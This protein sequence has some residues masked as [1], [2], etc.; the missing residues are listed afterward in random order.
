MLLSELYK[1]RYLLLVE[2]SL[3]ILYA[4]YD[5][6]PVLI[7]ISVILLSIILFSVFDRPILVIHF[8]IFS[9][10]I[11]AIV[12]VTSNTRGPTLLIE[13][14]F[15]LIFVGLGT[16]KILLSLQK[17]IDI[18]TIILLWIPFLIW[19]LLSGLAE[20]VEKLRILVFWKNY[21]A[22]F[23]AL[24]YTY[25]AIKNKLNLKSVV[26]GIIVW[27]LF[28]SLIEI[29]ILIELGG[30]TTGI[31]GLFF[32]KNLLSVGWGKSNYLAAF[33]VLIIPITIGYLF[34]TKSKPL[35]YFLV[36]TLAFMSF[37]LILTLSR[38][39]ILALLI[40]LIILF[41]KIIKTRTLIPFLLVFFLVAMV[42]LLNPL[43]YVLIDRISSIET[44][45]SYFS[46]INFY[47]DV[48]YTFLK[49]PITGVGFG[50]LGYYAQFVLSVDSSSSAHN[51]VLGI[52]GETGIV[53]AFFYFTLVGVF[54]RKVYVGFKTEKDESVKILRWSF[55]AA[56]T[57][58]LIHSLMEPTLE[59][60]Q[61]SIIFWV[62][63]GSYLKM[64]LLTT[65]YSQN[66]SIQ[67]YR[68]TSG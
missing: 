30:F 23:F 14:L 57:G 32:K 51:I 61:F 16:I 38:G 9:I 40:A 5:V 47:R 67:K 53:G 36:F 6:V 66:E 28:L 3:L 18:P 20:G 4:R 12:P 27:G 68:M 64:D 13:E 2:L 22:G 54:L 55:L 26:I 31:L 10:L 56:F 52:L 46:R 25:Y 11:D 44:S 17:K 21:F 41:S 7:V 8:L 59:G 1:L 49:H 50:N 29:K 37:A 45:G 62:V 24:S 35:K 60:L 48:W 15:L 42:V 65:S 43:T 58:A 63:A 39:G 19:S 34:H 33:F